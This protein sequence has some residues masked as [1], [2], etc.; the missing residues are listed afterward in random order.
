MKIA[1]PSAEGKLCAHF[2]HSESF[3]FVDVDSET[4]EILNLEN[5]VPEGG[6]SCHSATWVA[7]QGV[8]LV[9][10]GGMGGRPQ[11]VFEES[12]I[13][14]VFGCPEM[15]IEELVKA[16]MEQSLQTGENSCGGEHHNCHHEGG[17]HHHH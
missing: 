15:E 16:Y 3:T 2:G 9:L 14:V 4:G 5:I 6:V 10:A 8:N 17:C 13:P 1:I 12:G 11:M 7:Q